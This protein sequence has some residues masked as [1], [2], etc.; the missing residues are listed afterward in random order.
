MDI[1]E[2]VERGE[3]ENVQTENSKVEENGKWIMKKFVKIT[4]SKKILK[5]A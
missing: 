5:R 2:D 4:C 1:E 3:S